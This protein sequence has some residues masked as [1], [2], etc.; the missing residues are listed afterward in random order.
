[1]L[2]IELIF[3]KFRVKV[4]ENEGGFMKRKFPMQIKLQL[5]N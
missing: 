3:K 2:A 4:F 5:R 1:M